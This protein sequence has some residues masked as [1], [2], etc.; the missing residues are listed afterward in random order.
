MRGLLTKDF[1]TIKKKYGVPRL[2]IDCAIIVSLMVI[3]QGTEAIYV[4][5]LLIPLEVTS[6]VISL[7]TC[8]DQWKWGKYAVSLPVSKRQIVQ[9]RYAFAGMMALVGFIVALTVNLI[10]YFCFPAYRLGFYLFISVSSLCVTLI[11]LSFILPSNYSLG[12]NAGFAAMII[13]VV[14][15]II[16][17]IW[18]RLTGNAVMWFIVNHFEVSMGIALAAVILLCIAS[19]KLSITFFRHKYI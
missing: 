5:F 15:L 16:L 1:F 4:S 19:Y 11:F 14:L 8:D 6:M 13:L 17:G 7:A 12:V 9:S 2:L 18:S 10:S 3:L